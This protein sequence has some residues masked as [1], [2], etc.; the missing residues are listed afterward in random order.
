MTFL[1]LHNYWCNNLRWKNIYV[2][3][4]VWSPRPTSRRVCPRRQN[5]WLER[6]LLAPEIIASVVLFHKRF[7]LFWVF[8]FFTCKHTKSF[9]E[10][11]EQ[12]QFNSLRIKM[13]KVTFF[14]WKV[15]VFGKEIAQCKKCTKQ[16]FAISHIDRLKFWKI[17]FVRVQFPFTPNLALEQIT[18]ESEQ[19]PIIEKVVSLQKII[20]RKKGHENLSLR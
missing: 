9:R 13:I 5:K 12:N 16:H 8:W 6:Y 1:F 20:I 2:Q 18:I 4:F 17:L 3:Q 15:A 10:S 19:L 11:Q 14:D 7:L